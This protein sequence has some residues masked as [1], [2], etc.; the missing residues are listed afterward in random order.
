MLGPRSRQARSY[1]TINRM[2][3]LAVIH[4]VCLGGGLEFALACR[5]R[6]A[7]DDS[8][9][10]MGLPETTLGLIPG[11]GG[12]MRLPRLVGLRAALR[13]D[14]GREQALGP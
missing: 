4:G 6:V 10:R 9:T 11:W 5:Y 1:S 12:T 2:P 7:R 14:L 3:T 13:H 8:S